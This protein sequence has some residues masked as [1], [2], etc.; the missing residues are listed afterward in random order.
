[1]RYSAILLIKS[2]FNIH[3]TPQNQTGTLDIS[4]VYQRYKRFANDRDITHARFLAIVMLQNR[5]EL[6]HRDRSCVFS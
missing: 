5:S 1:M 6:H 4:Q 2:A 3:D